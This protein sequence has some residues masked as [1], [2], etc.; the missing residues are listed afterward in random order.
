ML[1]PV[2]IGAPG[3]PELLLI[4]LLV[5]VIFGAGKLPSVFRSLGEGLKSFREGQQGISDLDSSDTPPKTLSKDAIQD[6]EE[7]KNRVS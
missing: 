7:V 3:V 4:L 1:I 6:A 5:L 2:A